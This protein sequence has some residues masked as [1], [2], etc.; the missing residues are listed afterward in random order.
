MQIAL[1]SFATDVFRVQADKDY[2]AARSNYRLQLR[3]Q[4]LWAGL[5]AVEKYLKA[6]LLFNGQSARYP[7]NSRKPYLHGLEALFRAVETQTG[8]TIQYPKWVPDFIRYL[9]EFGNNRYLSNDT[10]IRGDAL[11][12][13][14]ETVWTLRRYCQFIRVSVP[15]PG[16]G[17]KDLFN[18]LLSGINSPEALK[19]PRRYRPFSGY[20]ESVLS[21]A[22]SHPARKALI[23]AN[24]FYGDRRANIT[25]YEMN[26]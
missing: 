20:L 21:S 25:R 2:I 16:G 17:R 23:W 8:L 26:P 7:P 24:L 9:H 11:P 13:L 1:N 10:Y 19:K 6:I 12:Q 4:F 18:L 14:D 22:H 3:E 5:Q 15:E